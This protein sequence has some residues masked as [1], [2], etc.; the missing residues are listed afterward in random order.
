MKW[1]L[2]NQSS[3]A[4]RKYQLTE[5]DTVKLEVKYNPQQ[6][7]IRI[8]SAETHR[9]F[10]VGKTGGLFNHKTVLK[11]EYGVEIGRIHVDKGHRSGNME[12]EGK[13]FQFTIQQNQLE[14]YE[15]SISSP[16][17]VCDLSMAP[18]ASSL[19]PHQYSSEECA[20][21]LLGLCWQHAEKIEL[22]LA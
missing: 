7:S 2:T 6:Q 22:A 18:S 4:M 15:H 16:L 3:A 10:F 5:G 12:V 17:A 13:K 11:N 9:L 20:C 19:H 1:V 21:L 14:V 8:S